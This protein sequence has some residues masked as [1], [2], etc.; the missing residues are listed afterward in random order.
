MHNQQMNAVELSEL[1]QQ[2]QYIIHTEI[3]VPAAWNLFNTLNGIPAL[4]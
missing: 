2:Q 4:T 3:K 1:Q